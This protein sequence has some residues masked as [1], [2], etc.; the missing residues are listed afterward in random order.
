M[1]IVLV[2]VYYFSCQIAGENSVSGKSCDWPTWD[3]F[4]LV[5]VCLKVNAEMV[6]KTPS[7]YCISLFS[8]P[9]LNFLDPYF[10]FMYKHYNHC[11]FAIKFTIIIIIADSLH[12][13]D[14]C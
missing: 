7:C 13:L 6:P 11:P 12:I 2:C 4:L 14:V 10:I 9:N 8:P 3:R 5:S 1:C